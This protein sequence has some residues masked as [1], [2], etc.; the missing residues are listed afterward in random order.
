MILCQA[1][2]AVQAVGACIRAVSSTVAG[3]PGGS[4][5]EEPYHDG[6][7]QNPG[8]IQGH[9]S[10]PIVQ[11]IIT[12]SASSVVVRRTEIAR[13]HQ[14]RRATSS[15][16]G[17]PGK[18]WSGFGQD[19][20]QA[21]GSSSRNLAPVPRP[22]LSA[23]ARPSIPVHLDNGQLDSAVAGRRDRGYRCPRRRRPAIAT[24]LSV[25]PSRVAARG[26]RAPSSRASRR[27]AVTARPRG[28]GPRAWPSDR[29]DGR[30]EGRQALL[31][32]ACLEQPRRGQGARD[33]DPRPGHR[34]LQAQGVKGG[35]LDDPADRLDLAK[36]GEVVGAG[37]GSF[38]AATQAPQ[39]A[40]LV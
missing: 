13:R 15:V 39:A 35:D 5:H 16:H 28:R 34:V 22:R 40:R 4:A 27:P 11:P 20:R 17:G 18:D 36:P 37:D 38:A 12:V 25:S 3:A 14:P 26:E 23:Q 33:Q 32:G 31:E 7:G 19:R 9:P 8:A 1:A 2:A 29:P 6:D 21:A 30:L 10:S 24:A